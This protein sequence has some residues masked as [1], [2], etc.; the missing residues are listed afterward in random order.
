MRKWLVSLGFAHG[1]RCQRK[2]N[3]D[4]T[5][6]IRIGGVTSKTDLFFNCVGGSI[7]M[8]WCEWLGGHDYHLVL[9][10]VDCIRIF[11]S[12]DGGQPGWSRQ[13]EKPRGI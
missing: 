3:H 6:S 9:V 5:G 4:G 12:A 7:L 10:A 13:V 1:P 11:Y 2:R 8:T